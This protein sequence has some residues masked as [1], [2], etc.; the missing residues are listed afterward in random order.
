VRFRFRALTNEEQ[1]TIKVVA[2]VGLLIFWGTTGFTP[3]IAIIGIVAGLLGIDT[4][5]SFA[6]GNGKDDE[7]TT[8]V[9]KNSRSKSIPMD[10]GVD[11]ASK[12]IIWRTVG[13]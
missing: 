10:D 8:L 9:K 5:R 3:N 7:P 6:K 2:G 4:I 12:R 11:S 1:A 13:S